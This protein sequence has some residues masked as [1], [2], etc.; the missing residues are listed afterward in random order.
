MG[1]SRSPLKGVFRAPF[2]PAYGF[3]AGFGSTNAVKGCTCG[4]AVVLPFGSGCADMHSNQTGR[5]YVGG[6]GSTVV[7][8]V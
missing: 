1:S 7:L 3:G 5:A 2:A 4:G 8:G 6:E